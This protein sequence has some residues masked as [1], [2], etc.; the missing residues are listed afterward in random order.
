M[1]EKDKK[2][3]KQYTAPKQY[4]YFNNQGQLVVE[5]NKGVW[6][7]GEK[8]VKMHGDFVCNANTL[9]EIINQLK[10][11]PVE[12]GTEEQL[13]IHSE[14]VKDIFNIEDTHTVRRYCILGCDKSRVYEYEEQLAKQHYANDRVKAMSGEIQKLRKDLKETSSQFNDASD[15]VLHIK[16]TIDKYNRLPWWKRMFK[17]IEVK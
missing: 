16:K 7:D 14:L 8:H 9:G 10:G 5:S 4:F 17:K 6:V 15:E 2:T 1:E 13:L 12:I 3:E 11:I